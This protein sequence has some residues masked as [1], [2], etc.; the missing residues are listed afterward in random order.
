MPFKSKTFMDEPEPVTRSRRTPS[1]DEPESEALWPQGKTLKPEQTEAAPGEVAP[2]ESARAGELNESATADSATSLSASSL[3]E[4]RPPVKAGTWPTLRRAHALSFAGLLLFTAVTYFRPYELI[5]ALSGFKTMAFWLAVLTLLAYLPTQLSTEGTLTA[6]PRE[7]N[8]AL[9]LLLAALASLPLAIEPGEGW[10]AF[11]DFAKVITMFIVMVNVVRTELRWRGMFWLALLV[12]LFLSIHALNDY[13]TGLLALRG[14]RIEGALGGLFD[15]P[16]DMA[17]HLVTTIPLALGL[18]F[19]ARGLSKKLF[20]GLCVLLM[21]AATV[22]TFSR[23]GFLALACSSF[24]MA[25]KFGRR[26]RFAVVVMFLAVGAVFFLIVPSDFIG[27]LLSIF[28]GDVDGGSAVARQ[29]LLL[30]SILVT[31]RHPLLGIGMANF[32]NVSISEQVSH[33]AYTQV[34]AEMG[35]PAMIV[36]VLF[37]WTAIRRMRKIEQETYETRTETRVY[38]LAVGLQASLIAYMISSFFASVAY[39]WYIYFLVGYAV[40][41]H[42]LY[43][44]KGPENAFGRGASAG[45]RVSAVEESKDVSAASFSGPLVVHHER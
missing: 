14:D 30:R 45:K 6:R 26:N 19:I 16:N 39:L 34:S 13:L 25:W 8:L 32:H 41:L 9:L 17:L 21:V 40:C 24:L 33:N 15:N 31:I 44:A 38:Y 42:R 7:V 22:V 36:Y 18:L 35:V 12:S 37:I 28:G 27:R 3:R 5:N 23:G 2:K 11:V 1:W 4:A 20:Y 10:A 29:N 43:E